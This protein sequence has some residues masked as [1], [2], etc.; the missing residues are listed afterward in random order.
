MWQ[1]SPPCRAAP[2]ASCACGQG[3]SK[4][5]A[6]NTHAPG[7]SVMP[8]LVCWRDRIIGVFASHRQQ[9]RAAASETK[10]SVRRACVCVSLPR[11]T[12]SGTANGHCSRRLACEYVCNNCEG[13]CAEEDAPRLSDEQ[14]HSI[15]TL[16]QE[17]KQPAAIATKLGVTGDA[18]RSQCNRLCLRAL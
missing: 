10:S 6:R 9:Q 14:R 3:H 8:I 18:V 17:G 15:V 7:E 13:L 4:S 16:Q 11:V 1:L 5:I 2:L 12:R